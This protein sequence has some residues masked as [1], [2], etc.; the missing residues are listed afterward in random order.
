MFDVMLRHL[1]PSPPPPPPPPAVRMI[2]AALRAFVAGGTAAGLAGVACFAF[3]ECRKALARHRSSKSRTA[4]ERYHGFLAEVA[5]YDPDVRDAYEGEAGD[6]RVEE[7]YDH[8][9]DVTVVEGE[10]TRV[11]KR[12]SKKRR[13][14]KKVY[15]HQCVVGG[16]P[17]GPY[18][19]DVVAS[20]RLQYSHRAATSYNM[21]LAKGY[22]VRL[23]QQHGMR[24][25]HIALVIDRMVVACFVVTDEQ[26]AVREDE[27]V[28]RAAGRFGVEG[29]F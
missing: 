7:E 28:L 8:V 23:M 21:A 16:E 19:S 18:C 26:L 3:V 29:S 10:T 14:Q 9:E 24:P 15:V 12:T 1:F 22:M 20:A 5:S 2:G 27:R 17:F 25:S 13:L 11:E 4:V 6:F